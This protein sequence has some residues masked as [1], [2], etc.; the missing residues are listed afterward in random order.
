M[1]NN[2]TVAFVTIDQSYNLLGRK[3]KIMVP[4]L[5]AGWPRWNQ[6]RVNYIAF[7]FFKLVRAIYRCGSII[8]SHMHAIYIMYININS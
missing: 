4:R 8:R 3:R 2:K 1:R 7:F 6:V 5:P